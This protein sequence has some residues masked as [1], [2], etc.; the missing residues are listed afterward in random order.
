MLTEQQ[1]YERI[2]QRLTDGRGRA[3]QQRP[4]REAVCR[5]RV[6]QRA[7]GLPCA[8]GC[9]IANEHYHPDLELEPA[10]ELQIE[11]PEGRP[12]CWFSWNQNI[13]RRSLSKALEFSGVPAT[14][15]TLDLLLAAQDV[16]DDPSCWDKEKGVVIPE[17]LERLPKP[18]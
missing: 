5:Y 9:L 16:H 12:P 8:V 17:A 14:E 10:M 11:T 4:L 13:H 2:V 15:Y 7:D 6:G 3:A 1:V 18:C